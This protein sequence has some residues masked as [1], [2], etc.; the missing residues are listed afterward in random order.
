M[1]RLGVL[2]GLVCLVSRAAWAADGPGLVLQSGF[3]ES[4][5]EQ[6]YYETIGQGDPVVFSH[7]LGGNHAIWYQ[8]VP[9]FARLYKVITWDQRGFGRSTNAQGQSGPP[10]AVEDLEAVLDRL[11]IEKAHLVGQSM[12]GWA[13]LG[14]ALKHPERVSSVVMADTIGGIYT[15]EIAAHF[16]A[17]IRTVVSS[18]SPAELP[19]T[20]HPA[21]GEA[22][23]ASDPAQAFL[24]R[25]IGGLSAPPPANMGLLLRQTAYPLED[26]KTLNLPVLFVVG[27][28]DPI[29]PPNVIRAASGLLAGSRL[30]QLPNAGHSPYFETPTAWNETVLGFLSGL[31]D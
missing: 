19:I 2:C 6:I 13:V 7:G 11:E 26:I 3:V 5:G 25:Q 14:F 4:G 20:L 22:L 24:Y 12:G 23:G 17:Y 10:A 9:E 8:Q 31:N 30:V 16:D 18:P 28:N 15:D 27:E 21:L 29:F 1:H